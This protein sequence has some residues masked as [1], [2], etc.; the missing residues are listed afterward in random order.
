M[1][2]ETKQ[3]QSQGLSQFAPLRTRG[4]RGTGNE[5]R[6][7]ESPCVSPCSSILAFIPRGTEVFLIDIAAFH[8][9]K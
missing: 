8:Q 1:L 5:V 6:D 4:E 7:E 3:P 2:T 9:K